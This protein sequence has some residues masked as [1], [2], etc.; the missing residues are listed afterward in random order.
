MTKSRAASRAARR[1]T[2]IDHRVSALPSRPR[3][4]LALPRKRLRLLALPLRQSGRKKIAPKSKQKTKTRGGGGGLKEERTR[5]KCLQIRKPRGRREQQEMSRVRNSR[6]R[7]SDTS[8]TPVSPAHVRSS[9]TPL[10]VCR[11]CR[12]YTTENSLHSNVLPVLYL[13]VLCTQPL[14]LDGKK[15]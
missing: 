14:T 11:F 13:L 4:L 2:L 5:K 12:Q 15:V 8:D 7:G 6:K 1:N 10:S 3:R 9:Q